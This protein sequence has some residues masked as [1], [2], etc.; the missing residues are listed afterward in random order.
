MNHHIKA[1]TVVQPRLSVV[2][3]ASYA[4]VVFLRFTRSQ[5]K[6]YNV[7]VLEDVTIDIVRTKAWS[8]KNLKKIATASSFMLYKKS[9][10][11]SIECSIAKT[12][13]RQNNSPCSKYVIYFY[14]VTYFIPALLTRFLRIIIKKNFVGIECIRFL[15]SKMADALF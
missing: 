13:P 10:G 5:C 2:I 14:P 3:E 1:F 15:P 11:K 4:K 6:H 7:E 8:G 12:F 9:E